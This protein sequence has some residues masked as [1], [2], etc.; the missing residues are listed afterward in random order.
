AARVRGLVAVLRSGV[1]VL[2]GCRLDRAHLGVSDSVGLGRGQ[3]LGVGLDLFFG[4]DVV[5]AVALDVA[6]EALDVVGAALDVVG[7]VAL[8]LV[9]RNR[10]VLIGRGGSGLFSR[11]RRRQSIELRRFAGA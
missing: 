1:G 8:G 10:L 6:G 7:A 3:H 4:L 9:C 11:L 5:G 2:I